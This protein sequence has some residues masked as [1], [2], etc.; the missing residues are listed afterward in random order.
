[1][2]GATMGVEQEL[3]ELIL[4]RYKSVLAFCEA[5]GMPYSTVDSI[6][7]RGVNNSSV[8]KV[9]TIC[10]ELNIDA[11][12]LADG[13]IVER[14]PVEIHAAA[15]HFDLNQL[16]DEGVARYEEYITFLAEKYAKSKDQ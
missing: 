8:A 5:A 13:R 4:Q 1:M 2:E 6:F 7:K 15:A 9:I 11:D 16:T 3:K 12:E 14:K 10:K